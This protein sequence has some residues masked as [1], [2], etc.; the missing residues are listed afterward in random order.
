MKLKEAKQWYPDAVKSTL[1]VAS[2][3]LMTRNLYKEEEL[4]KYLMTLFPESSILYCS[5]SGR[6]I[7]AI[8][9]ESA[10]IEEK[11]Q[12]LMIPETKVVMTGAEGDIPKYKGK[13]WTVYA[14]PKW[15]CGEFVVWLQ[16]FSGAYSCKYLRIVK[17][18]EA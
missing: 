14:G 8:T 15:M 3:V 4:R 7:Q 1:T 6:T 17:E 2:K 16:G 13:V 9:S 18:E 11:R 5:C 10:M 12:R